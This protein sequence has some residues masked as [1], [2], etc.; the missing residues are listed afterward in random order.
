[1]SNT[2]K[3]LGFVVPHLTVNQLSYQLISSANRVLLARDDLD[4]I[5]FWVNDG[6]KIVKPLFSTMCIFESYGYDGITIA[7]NLSTASRILD[8]PGPN[9]NKLYYY[10]Y[11][12]DWLRIPQRQYESLAS[13]Y[14]NPKINLIARSKSHFDI[15]KSVWKEPIGIVEGADA[16]EFVKLLWK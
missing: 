16:Q 6:L 14:M 9:R 11:D 2:V 15:I 7:T 12:L 10:V 5:L 13:I 4:V 8:Y 1:M 3:K